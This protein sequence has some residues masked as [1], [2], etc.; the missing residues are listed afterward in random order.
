M[1][2][3][4]YWSS[5]LEK[6]RQTRYIDVDVN[7]F[8]PQQAAAYTHFQSFLAGKLQGPNLVV[9]GPSRAGKTYFALAGVKEYLKSIFNPGESMMWVDKKGNSF[10][11]WKYTTYCGSLHDT[12]R[13]V[14]NFDKEIRDPARSLLNHYHHTPLLIIDDFGYVRISDDAFA[15]L[16]D[17]ID[18]RYGAK[19]KTIFITTLTSDQMVSS[20]NE[21]MVNRMLNR[22]EPDDDSH[23]QVIS[24]KSRL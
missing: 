23:K 24:L 11:H 14:S 10:Y 5:E 17:L 20:F 7:K 12:F 9:V 21:A 3:E 22:E 13:D 1:T 19:L 15:R 2:Y 4:Q 18:K 6:L 16:V 8:S